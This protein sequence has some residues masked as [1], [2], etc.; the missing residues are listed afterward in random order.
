MADSAVKVAIMIVQVLDHDAALA[1]VTAAA[2]QVACTQQ[3][4]ATVVTTA[5]YHFAQ[6]ANVQSS[7]ASA[8][9]QRR[10]TS[11]VRALQSVISIVQLHVLA[12]AKIAQR[13]HQHQLLTTAQ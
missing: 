3:Y 7:A 11:T 5:K 6:L 8:S 9:A 2:H 13:A 10:V 4:A 1:V 12:M